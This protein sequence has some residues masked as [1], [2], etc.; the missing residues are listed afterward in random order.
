MLRPCESCR[1]DTVFI[2][3][4]FMLVHHFQVLFSQMFGLIAA[5]CLY[6]AGAGG[7]LFFFFS[8][9]FF[10]YITLSSVAEVR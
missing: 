8:L 9:V 5:K 2:Y 6:W 4:T 7:G 1:Y 10:T 3:I